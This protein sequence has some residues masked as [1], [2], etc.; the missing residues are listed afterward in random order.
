MKTS[1]VNT[2]I[3]SAISISEVWIH[4]HWGQHSASVLDED[5][6]LVASVLQP[7]G[8][9]KGPMLIPVSPGVIGP[10]LYCVNHS[11]TTG[12]LQS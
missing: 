4:A 5:I 2:R 11:D 1:C 10:F 8:H 7:D 3:S 12:G 9:M 6:I